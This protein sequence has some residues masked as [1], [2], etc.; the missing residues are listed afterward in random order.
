MKQVRQYLDE[1]IDAGVAKN[2]SDIA[3]KLSVT[4]AAVSD[5]RNGRRA[6]EDDA[7]V[8]LA[9][10][11]GKPEGELLAECAAAR[12][13]NPATRAA[14]ERLAKMA[15]MSLGLA[16]VPFVALYLTGDSESAMYSIA[17]IGALGSN[18]DY[19]VFALATAL[20]LNAFF[21]LQAL[22]CPPTGRRMFRTT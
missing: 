16:V 2:D 4:R 14:W 3:R 20:M 21:T 13:K 10:L 11:L 12:A 18:T 9:H 7:A 15:S 6:P 17:W 1:A 22:H 19:G 8:E 5:W